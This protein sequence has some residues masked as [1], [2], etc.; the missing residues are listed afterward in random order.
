MYLWAVGMASAVLAASAIAQFAY[1]HKKKFV[2]T[3]LLLL[4]F[5]A[6][7]SR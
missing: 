6:T 1:I 3:G 5:L 2:L 4:V 7:W